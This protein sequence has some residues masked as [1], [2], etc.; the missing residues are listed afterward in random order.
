M[1]FR[2]GASGNPGGRPKGSRNVLSTEIRGL[3]QSLLDAAYWTSIQ[4]RLRAGTLPPALESRLWSYAYGDPQDSADKAKGITVNIGFLG[5]RPADIA[6]PVMSITATPADTPVM[7]TH[8]PLALIA[9]SDDE[10]A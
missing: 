9:P 5:S 4:T 2:K 10:N 6:T 7:A 8:A 1:P 3:A